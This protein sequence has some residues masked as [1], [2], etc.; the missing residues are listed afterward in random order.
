MIRFP[1]YGWLTILFPTNRRESQHYPYSGLWLL[2]WHVP[3]ASLKVRPTEQMA[4]R[5]D[6][7]L[8]FSA[9]ELG[10][11]GPIVG[12]RLGGGVDAVRYRHNR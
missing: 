5:R 9:A 12:V 1:L 2:P 6:K 11:N 8:T 4:D 7:A 3:P 10:Y